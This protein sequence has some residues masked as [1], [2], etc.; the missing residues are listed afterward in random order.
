MPQQGEGNHVRDGFSVF[1]L[2]WLDP[3]IVDG[4]LA[5][6]IEG[7]AAAPMDE[8]DGAHRAA[9]FDG[10]LEHQRR[11]LQSSEG[12]LT[13]DAQPRHGRLHLS[14]KLHFDLAVTYD[15]RAV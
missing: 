1:V 5:R 11:V 2:R 15:D 3:P 4:L 10:N 6:L 14:P 7:D 8:I 12:E 9:G 13:G